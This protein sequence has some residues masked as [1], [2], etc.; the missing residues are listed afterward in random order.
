MNNRIKMIKHHNEYQKNKYPS[1]SENMLSKLLLC[2][3]YF[4]MFFG[5]DDFLYDI[6]FFD[7]L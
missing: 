2:S 5:F 4:K 3:L 7:F 1:V 6:N